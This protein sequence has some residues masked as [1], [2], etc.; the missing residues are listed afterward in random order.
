MRVFALFGLAL[1]LIGAGP[2]HHPRKAP[3][4]DRLQ[5]VDLTYDF[6]HIWKQTKDLPDSERVEAFEARFGGVLPGFYSAERVKY[7]MTPERHR[8]SVL[9][10]L[11]DYPAKR[12]GIQRVSRDFSS[13][14]K[15][16]QQQFEARFGPMT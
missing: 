4:S 10:G 8:A 9:K 6:D 2:G 12:A 13:L 7:Y 14:V 11:N 1:A 16:A 5:F 3:A 15:P